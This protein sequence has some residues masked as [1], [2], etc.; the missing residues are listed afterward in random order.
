MQIRHIFK[1]KIAYNKS[2]LKTLNRINLSLAG[3]VLGWFPFQ[4]MT[5]RWL[6]QNFF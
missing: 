1:K 3:M 5:Q 6:H 2:S 4:G